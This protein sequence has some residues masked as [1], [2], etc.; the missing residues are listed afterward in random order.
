M[1]RKIGCYKPILIEHWI[2]LTGNVF[3]FRVEVVKNRFD[4]LGL[5]YLF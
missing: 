3:E 1:Q 5:G 4:S 2:Y